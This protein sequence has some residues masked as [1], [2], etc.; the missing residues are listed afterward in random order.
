MLGAWYGMGQ[1][2]PQDYSE[3]YF[4]SDVAAAGKLDASM[5]ETATTNRDLALSLLSPDELAR[6]QEQARIWFEAHRAKP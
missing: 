2:V 1:G 6:A 4:W 3:A 5:A